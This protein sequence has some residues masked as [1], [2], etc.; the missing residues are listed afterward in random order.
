MHIAYHKNFIKNFKKR[1]GS[2]QKVKKS[3]NNRLKLFIKNP[4]HPL[5][6][7]H[8]L[9]GR[10]ITLRAFS[11]TGNVR[12]VYK[13]IGKKIIFLDIGTHNQVY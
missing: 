11:V 7:D 8:S 4:N 13:E 6:K 2:N 1:F 3:Y 5:P 10:K 12:V 9:K